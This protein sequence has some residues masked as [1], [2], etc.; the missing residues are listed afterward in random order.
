MIISTV[1]THQGLGFETPENISN[2]KPEEINTINDLIL[3][4]ARTTPTTPLIAYPRSDSAGSELAEYT[5]KDLDHFADAVAKEFA[6]SGLHPKV[7]TY[8]FGHSILS[9]SFAKYMTGLA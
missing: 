8:R 9:T 1:S 6:R 7:S 5:A 3:Y 2:S 4:K